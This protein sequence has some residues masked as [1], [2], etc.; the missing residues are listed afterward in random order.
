MF[1]TYTTLGLE[2]RFRLTQARIELQETN[3][4]QC[5]A[6]ITET[7][8]HKNELENKSML[9]NVLINHSVWPNCKHS[10]NC[11][12]LFRLHPTFLLS[13]LWNCYVSVYVSVCTNVSFQVSVYVLWMFFVC[14]TIYIR[15]TN[16]FCLP[17]WM[18]TGA[19]NCRISCRFIFGNPRF[20]QREM[21]A[22]QQ[23]KLI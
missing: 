16:S 12:C 6:Y 19:N 2:P 13:C 14:Y 5:L 15:T 10:V 9:V 23:F 4:R 18:L 22:E 20:A 3:V 8:E 21:Y 7:F 17:Y 11:W 1:T